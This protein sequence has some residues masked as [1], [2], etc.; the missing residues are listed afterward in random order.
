MMLTVTVPC[1]CGAVKIG[2]WYNLA[3]NSLSSVVALKRTFQR[4][5]A[6]IWGQRFFRDRLSVG[7]LVAALVVNGLTFVM[8]VLRLRPVDGLTPVRFTNLTLFDALGPWYF[9]FEIAL[10]GLGVTVINGWFAYHG[11]GRSRLASF[12]LL[13][14]ALVVGMFCAI[15]AMAFGAVR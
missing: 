3:M 12:F 1:R 8:L 15:I 11:F 5:V 13:I 10:F 9:P 14:S 6:D 7:L 2:R 4:M